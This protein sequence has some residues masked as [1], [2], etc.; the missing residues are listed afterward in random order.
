MNLRRS[1]GL[2]EDYF[3]EDSGSVMVNYNVFAKYVRNANF[4]MT[5]AT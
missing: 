5:G 3:A 2:A 4:L 1:R